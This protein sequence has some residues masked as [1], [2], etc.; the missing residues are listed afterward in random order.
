MTASTETGNKNLVVL[1][2]EGHATILGHVA[3]NSFVVLFELHSHTL[4][5]GGV[6][7]L[8]LDTNLLDDD[9]GSLGGTSERLLPLGDSVSLHER[10]LSPSLRENR[11]LITRFEGVECV[12]STYL[13]SLLLIRSLR[14]A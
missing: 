13:L 8:S 6:R 4:T 2:D 12:L 9:A 14:P 5:D 7:L 10:L 1:I 3:S 11:T